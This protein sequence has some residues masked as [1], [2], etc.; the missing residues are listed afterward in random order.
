MR[1]RLSQ[2]VQSTELIPDK[3]ALEL[4]PEALLPLHGHLPCGLVARL[5]G[6]KDGCRHFD[7]HL[8]VDLVDGQ[9]L[10][11]DGDHAFWTA[12]WCLPSTQGGAS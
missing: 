6:L 8:L 9:S 2:T 12:G 10:A 11:S 7:L 4:G 3:K 1:K 5:Q